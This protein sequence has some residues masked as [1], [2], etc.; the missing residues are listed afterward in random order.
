[1]SE[2]QPGEQDP[3]A[4][5]GAEECNPKTEQCEM[6]MVEG[7]RAEADGP[8]FK[9]EIFDAYSPEDEMMVPH[10]VDGLPVPAH[11]ASSGTAYAPPFTHDHVVCVEDD[12]AY[13]EMFNEELILHGMRDETFFRRN[14][15]DAEGVQL[16]RK[17]FTPDRVTERWGQKVVELSDEERVELNVSPTHKFIAVRPIRERCR[18]YSR[19]VLSQ[20]GV[21]EGEV[22]HQIIFRN[23]MIRRSIGGAFMSVRDEAVYACD[24]RDPPHSE[25][26]KKLDERDNDR[27]RSNAHKVMLPLFR[28]D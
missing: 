27:L 19:Q 8:S 3:T 12:R 17:T 1:M 21:P 24:Y 5:V 4:E 28:K 20:D 25:S 6:R 22:G 23:C 2:K 26:I 15:F 7:D 14:R 13:V 18:Y 9:D 16:E 10:P 11:E